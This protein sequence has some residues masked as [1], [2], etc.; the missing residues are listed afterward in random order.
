MD[1]TPQETQ[2]QQPKFDAAA[3]TKQKLVFFVIAV[4]VLVII[5]F[6]LGW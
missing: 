2:S 6:A 3:E 5:K 4:L 1:P